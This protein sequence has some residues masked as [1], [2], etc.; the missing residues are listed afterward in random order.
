M[1]SEATRSGNKVDVLKSFGL[2]KCPYWVA[3]VENNE[4]FFENPP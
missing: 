4:G 1:L 3:K 2:D